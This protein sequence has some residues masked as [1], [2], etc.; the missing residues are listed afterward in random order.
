[1]SLSRQIC[2]V[3]DAD[4][5]F[6]C[7]QLDCQCTELG[8]L[9]STSGVSKLYFS[10]GHINYYTTVPAGHPKYCGCFGICSILTYQEMLSKQII[11]SSLTKCLRGPDEMASRGG[12]GRGA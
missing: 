4:P 7:F 11:F 10:E 3:F 8:F 6:S 1:M 12:F 5:T 9:S 2:S